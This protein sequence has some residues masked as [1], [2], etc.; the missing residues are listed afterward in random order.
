MDSAVLTY[1]RWY[2]SETGS[3][4]NDDDFLVGVSTDDGASWQNLETL[5]CADRTWT[6]MEFY[7]EDYVTL[8]NQMK[9]RFVAQDN[10]VGGSIV[11]AAVDDFLIMACEE[12][13]AD[14]EAPTVTV[15]APNG[16]E[17]CEH[18]ASYDIQWTA[19]DNVSVVSIAILLSTDSGL[20]FPDTVATGEANDGV[21]SWPVPDIDSRTARIRV[22]ALDAAS[23]SGSDASDSDFVLWGTISGIVTPGITDVPSSVVLTVSG[24][25]PTPAT[26]HITFGLPV[27]THVDLG[28][29]D[30]TGRLVRD[31]AGGQ[32]PEGFHIVDWNGEGRSESRVSPGI[33]FV[34]LDCTEG[35]RT[36]KIVIAN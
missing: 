33:Y 4:P 3:N 25:N 17:V 15:I 1:F 34:R 20:T 10:G 16:G 31:L 14:T 22:I 5:A 27:A 26:A 36:T 30:V 32:R 21:Y 29:Y 2:A 6:R 23:N 35:Q 12:S 13:V 18:G 28:V 9:F 24:G 8:T 7:L 11:E 19:T